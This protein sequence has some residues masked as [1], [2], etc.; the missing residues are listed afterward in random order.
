M[1]P[2]L[3]CLEEDNSQRGKRVN[4]LQS[5]FQSNKIICPEPSDLWCLITSTTPVCLFVCLFVDLFAA[6]QE[7]YIFTRAYLFVNRITQ[8]RFAVK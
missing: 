7:D 5:L 8:K 2:T 6:C 1:D 3:D 4:C